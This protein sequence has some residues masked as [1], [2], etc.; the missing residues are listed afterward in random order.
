[1]QNHHHGKNTD[2]FKLRLKTEKVP[3]GNGQYYLFQTR[4]GLKNC[5]NT[6]IQ[7]KKMRIECF[8]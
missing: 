7:A 8:P 5:S 6:L 2:S 3:L 1:M 4:K